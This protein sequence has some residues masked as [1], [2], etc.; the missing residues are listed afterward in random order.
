MGGGYPS[1]HRGLPGAGFEY[2]RGEQAAGHARSAVAGLIG[3]DVV[4]EVNKRLWSRH[5]EML[6][7]VT[8]CAVGPLRPSD[9][10]GGWPD[11]LAA[12]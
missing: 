11:C 10:G 6:Y 1:L 2:S 12:S 7:S 5:S 4:E 8:F 3:A 9:E